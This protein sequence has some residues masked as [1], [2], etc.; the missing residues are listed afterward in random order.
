MI[1]IENAILR[2]KGLEQI[3]TYMAVSDYA[4]AAEDAEI[5]LVLGESIC[6]IRESLEAAL[7]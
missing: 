7:E 5:F 3:C 6:A 1:A 4:R 2:L